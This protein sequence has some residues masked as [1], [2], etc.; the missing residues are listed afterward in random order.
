MAKIDFQLESGSSK[1]DFQPIDFQPEGQGRGFDI[2]GAIANQPELVRG[3]LAGVGGLATNPVDIPSLLQAAVSGLTAGSTRATLEYPALPGQMAQGAN[4]PANLINLVNLI[5]GGRTPSVQVPISGTGLTSGI[6]RLLGQP[7]IGGQIASGLTEIATGS[8]SPQF[9]GGVAGATTKTLSPIVSG[10]EKVF[11]SPQALKRV[12]SGIAKT[13]AEISNVPLKKLQLTEDLQKTRL[14]GKQMQ[15][16]LAEGFKAKTE[17]LNKELFSKSNVVSESSKQRLRSMF[18]DMSKT[19]RQGL[20][21]AENAMAVRGDLIMPQEYL[22]SVVSKTINSTIER[23]ISESEPAVQAMKKI[24][25]ALK[26]G[27][28]NTGILDRNGIE[29]V[30]PDPKNPI[31]VAELKDLRNRIYDTISPGFK[32]GNKYADVNDAVASNFL[33]NH[34][35]FIETKV[36]ELG[37]LNRE[38]RPLAQ[39]RNWAMKTFKPYNESEIER[40]ASVLRNIASG[41]PNQTSINYLKQ[42]ELGS[43]RFKG[44][45]KISSDIEKIGS[46][47]RATKQAFETAKQQLTDS[48]DF[49]I[50]K[51]NNQKAMIEK[52]NINLKFRTEKLKQIESSIKR[53]NTIRKT[54][55]G[56]VIGGIALQVFPSAK[57]AATEAIKYLP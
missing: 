44:T 33:S 30:L 21:D 26:T 24:Q 9:I 31:K 47:I 5:S 19:Y 23:G 48:I 27:Q 37:Q 18:S 42:L 43:G 10:T 20:D 54:I 46:D 2:R 28:R 7:T 13:Q 39:A 50:S 25:N 11:K 53:L 32:S 12:Q 16:K 4:L 35:D 41:K 51:L 8:V 38:F 56:I 22:D 52:R 45:G 29:I 55:I 3:A 57:R 49:Q 36:P 1:I 40:G 17:A 14:G 34:G 6:D 15:S